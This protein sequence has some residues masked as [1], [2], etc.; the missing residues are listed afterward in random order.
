MENSE[1]Y[2]QQGLSSVSLEHY[3]QQGLN[4]LQLQDL[5][6]SVSIEHRS[7]LYKMQKKERNEFN[8][9]SQEEKVKKIYGHIEHVIHEEDVSEEDSVV[10]EEDSVVSE[11]DS[12]VSEEDSVVSEEDESKDES[13]YTEEVIKSLSVKITTKSRNYTDDEKEL[14]NT[15]ISFYEE[16]INDTSVEIQFIFDRGLSMLWI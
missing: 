7:K 2:L 16:G 9:L 11:E 1:A 6:S 10:S 4:S 14:M 13:F 8:N 5:S 12:V 15:F 3:L